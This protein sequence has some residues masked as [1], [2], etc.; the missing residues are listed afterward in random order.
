MMN[1]D[2]D[3]LIKIITMLVPLSVTGSQN[4]F[5]QPHCPPVGM[6]VESW[7]KKLR[8][9]IHTRNRVGPGPTR[10]TQVD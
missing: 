2:D 9:R 10:L 8:L 6:Q 1:N 5:C 7:A 4:R 3:T